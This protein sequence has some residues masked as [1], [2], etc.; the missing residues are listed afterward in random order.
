MKYN[1]LGKPAIA[2]LFIRKGFTIENAANHSQCHR[3]KNFL[4]KIEK[5]KKEFEKKKT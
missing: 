5:L 3:A 1:D 4:I 2:E